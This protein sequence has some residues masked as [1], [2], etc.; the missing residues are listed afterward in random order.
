MRSPVAIT[1]NLLKCLMGIWFFGT[2]SVA[3]DIHEERQLVRAAK[4]YSG[5]VLPKQFDDEMKRYSA[6]IDHLDNEIHI[7]RFRKTWRILRCMYID[8]SLHVVV[9]VDQQ[10]VIRGIEGIYWPTWKKLE[11]SCKG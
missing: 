6:R 8:Y 2:V 5:Q 1:R 3:Y 11:C 4:K 9:F 10:N 7:I